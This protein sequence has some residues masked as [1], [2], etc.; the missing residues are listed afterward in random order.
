ML[1]GHFIALGWGASWG[2][3]TSIPLGPTGA[4]IL[5]EAAT[6][7]RKGIYAAIVGFSV[8]HVFFQTVF[9]LGY[10]NL[11]S[12]PKMTI[13]FS[14][15]GILLMLLTGIKCITTNFSILKNGSKN[16]QRY[17]ADHDASIDNVKKDNLIN[18]KI[19]T[20]SN[21]NFSSVKVFWR[22]AA[23]T[24][25]NPMILVF[26]AANTSVF[27]QSYPNLSSKTY[28]YTLLLSGLAGTVLWF[29]AFGEVINKFS[30]NWNIKKRALTEIISGCL[31]TAAGI[32]LAVKI[33]T[34]VAL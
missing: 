33:F 30:K 13:T 31:L 34:Q 24:I 16:S 32:S 12:N 3:V 9:H 7:R 26:I 15:F 22:S 1:I 25:L 23:M 19:E 6:G 17:S 20:N 10:S 28:I 5:S 11:T 2:I 27:V 18:L 14:I 4:L 8:A 29:S 21:T